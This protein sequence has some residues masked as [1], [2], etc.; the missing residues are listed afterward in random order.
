[1]ASKVNVETGII[2]MLALA[3]LS[4]VHMDSL[5]IKTKDERAEAFGRHLNTNNK[6]RGTLSWDQHRSMPHVDPVLMSALVSAH[7]PQVAI[8][9]LS[10]DLLVILMP[11]FCKYGHGVCADLLTEATKRAIGQAVYTKIYT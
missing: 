4:E 3:K 1:M 9:D 5:E 6:L 8:T 11:A 2:T 10:K 7:W